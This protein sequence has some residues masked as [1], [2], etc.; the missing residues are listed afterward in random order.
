MARRIL[1]VLVAALVSLG[2][3]AG[4]AP[5]TQAP[6]PR[7]VAFHVQHDVR[8]GAA[9][10]Q[11]L[12]LDAYV[13]DDTNAE[14][15]AV[16]VIHGG[17]W[18]TGDK[19]DVVDVAT[20]LARRGWVAF[21]VDYRL[22]EPEAFPA[23]IDDVEAAVTW[24]RA[25][26]YEYRMDPGRIGAIGFSAGG[27]LAAMLATE[28]EGPPDRGGR[29]LVG[30]S[31][32]GPM[33]LGTL[34]GG[35]APLSALLLPCPPADCP[36]RWADASPISHVD[37]TDAPL[38]LVNSDAELVPL[39]QA[40]AMAAR[41][42]SAGVEHQLVVVPGSRHGRDLIDDAW[43]ATV[44]FLDRHLVRPTD[45]RDPNPNGTWVL[46]VVILIVIAGGVIGGLRVRRRLIAA[47]AAAGPG[48]GPGAGDGADVN[49]EEPG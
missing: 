9:G 43:P 27:H 13:P 4:Q 12:L 39:D 8:Y 48:A 42:D 36:Q 33:D 45:L 22:E 20:H 5:T 32:S 46:L 30:V 25:N 10:G 15:V 3:A 44:A 47:A 38:L 35:L 37:A 19:R 28:G 6:A 1:V 26:A 41:L 18:R 49:R 14:R 31:W 34:A 40:Q 2:A 29:I 16:V 17:A 23:E 21:A 7:D 11:D 24:A